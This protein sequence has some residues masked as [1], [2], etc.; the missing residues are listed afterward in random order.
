MM[1][2]LG[3]GEQSFQVGLSQAIALKVRQLQRQAWRQNRGKEFLRAF[4]KAINRLQRSP[5]AFGEPLYQLPALRMQ[6][7]CAVL[8]PLSI[9]FGVCEDRPLVFIKEVKLL[10]APK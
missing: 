9:D 7:R 10:S 4:R 8:G 3:N 5:R 1:L 6:V 2:P